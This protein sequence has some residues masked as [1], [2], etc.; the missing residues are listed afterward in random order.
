MVIK[1]HYEYSYFFNIFEEV[2]RRDNNLTELRKCFSKKSGASRS[3][4]GSTALEMKLQKNKEVV[5]RLQ[6]VEI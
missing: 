3:K 5:L 4:D 2:F 6:Q 1:I